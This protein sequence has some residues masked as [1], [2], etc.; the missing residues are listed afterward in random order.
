MISKATS[1]IPIEIIEPKITQVFEI[2]YSMVEIPP[3]FCDT[4]GKFITKN[5]CSNESFRPFSCPF[6][7]DKL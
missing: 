3:P 2:A 6:N 5:E 7:K 4:C 1:A